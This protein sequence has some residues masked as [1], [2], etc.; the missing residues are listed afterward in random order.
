MFHHPTMNNDGGWDVQQEFIFRKKQSFKNIIFVQ[1][2]D[3][4]LLS[5]FIQ[6]TSRLGLIF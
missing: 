5:S 4:L 3:D 2:F 1:I 6:R